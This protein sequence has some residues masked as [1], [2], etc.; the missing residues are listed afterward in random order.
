ML[1][2]P[3]PLWDNCLA[4]IRDAVKPDQYKTWFEPIVFESYKPA[5][6]TL[7][8]RVPST[9]FYEYLTQVVSEGVVVVNKEYFHTVY[10]IFVC[11]NGL[12]QQA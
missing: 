3:K 8:L 5:T 12:S 9:F 1:A 6:K 2:S 7:L 4:V 11:V 10:N